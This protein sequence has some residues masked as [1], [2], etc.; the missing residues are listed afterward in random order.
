MVHVFKPRVSEAGGSHDLEGSLV[1]MASYRPAGATKRNLVSHTNS[2]ITLTLTLGT[3]ASEGSLFL[4]FPDSEDSKQ[5]LCGNAS[6][7]I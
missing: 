7:E 3:E 6:V 5:G 4:V 2:V 1:Y